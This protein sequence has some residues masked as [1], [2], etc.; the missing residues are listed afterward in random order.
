MLF[1]SLWCPSGSTDTGLFIKRRP[2]YEEYARDLTAFMY[3]NVYKSLREE[4]GLRTDRGLF[5]RGVETEGPA[6]R[7]GIEPGDAIL[8]IGATEA[9]SLEEFRNSLDPSEV[10]TFSEPP[11]EPSSE[12]KAYGAV[13]LAGSAGNRAELE[14]MPPWMTEPA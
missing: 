11:L 5:V 6:A 10:P 12:A 9:D 2:A 14:D 8:R 7:A 4:A 1:G 13:I 3:D